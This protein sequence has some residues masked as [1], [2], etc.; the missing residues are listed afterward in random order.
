MWS[1][2]CFA[3]RYSFTLHL[4]LHICIAHFFLVWVDFIFVCVYYKLYTRG[5]MLG[6]DPKCVMFRDDIHVFPDNTV[7]NT[8]ILAKNTCRIDQINFSRRTREISRNRIKF[9][10]IPVSNCLYFRLTYFLWSNLIVGVF[11]AGSRYFTHNMSLSSIYI[12]C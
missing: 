7:K 10:D 9:V 2:E 11:S 1:D 12:Y 4:G 6:F 3:F 5:L 8:L